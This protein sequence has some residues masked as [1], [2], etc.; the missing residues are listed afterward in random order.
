MVA[1]DDERENGMLGEMVR[2]V[3]CGGLESLGVVCAVLEMMGSLG[4]G[5]RLGVGRWVGVFLLGRRHRTSCVVRRCCCCLVVWIGH[6]VSRLAIGAGVVHLHRGIGVD[7][8]FLLYHDA[9][10]VSLLRHDPGAAFLLRH[11]AFFPRLPHD[12]FDV[13]SSPLLSPF[14]SPSFSPSSPPPPYTTDKASRSPPH[15]L[16]SISPY[17]RYSDAD[18]VVGYLRRGLGCGFALGCGR[19]GMR[20]LGFRCWGWSL[21]W[22]WG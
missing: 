21:A 17:S 15:P 5:M 16:Q 14:S 12:D 19:W 11:R 6:S 20:D 18:R 22:V 13:F 1:C 7:V 8:V 3:D 9:D 2:G 10:V 4:G